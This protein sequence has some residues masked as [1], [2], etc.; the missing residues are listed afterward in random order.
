MMGLYSISLRSKKEDLKFDFLT[1]LEKQRLYVVYRRQVLLETILNY[2]VSP[3]FQD[4]A[5]NN[6]R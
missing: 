2:L 5:K 1:L 6:R 3:V 4:A